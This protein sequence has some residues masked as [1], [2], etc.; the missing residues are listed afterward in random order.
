MR[1]R[2]ILFIHV[3]PI[4]NAWLQRLLCT[5]LNTK[6]AFLFFRFV[7]FPGWGGGLFFGLSVFQDVEMLRLFCVSRCSESCESFER[8]YVVITRKPLKNKKSISSQS[9]VTPVSYFQRECIRAQSSRLFVRSAH[10]HIAFL[11]IFFL[12]LGVFKSERMCV[13]VLSQ[14]RNRASK[15]DAFCGSNQTLP[16]CCPLRVI[17]TQKN[18]GIQMHFV[19]FIVVCTMYHAFRS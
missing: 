9:S 1:V 6:A 18:N 4:L 12:F 7:F 3:N 19:R 2:V 8:P 10:Y 5:L 15:R 17:Y 11:C 16:C 13:C 14:T